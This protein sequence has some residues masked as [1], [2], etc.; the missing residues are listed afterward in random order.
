VLKEEMGQLGLSLARPDWQG[1]ARRIPIQ[2]AMEQDMP[3]NML[4]QLCGEHCFSSVPMPS[5]IFVTV[6]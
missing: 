3:R 1:G 2:A 5:M 6:S 4:P